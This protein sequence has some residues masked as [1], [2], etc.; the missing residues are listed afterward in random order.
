MNL[1]RSLGSV[2]G[3][4]LASRILGARSRHAVRAVRRRQFRVRRFRRRLADAEHVPR[5][6]RGRRLLGG[7]H[8]DVQQKVADKEGPG[9]R[10]AST[11]PTMRCR[12][13]CPSCVLMTVL[14][15]LFAWPATYLISRD[16][17]GAVAR[18]VRLRGNAQP[19]HLPVPDADLL[20]SLLGGILNSLT[21][22]GSLPRRRSCSTSRRSS[23]F[24]FFH[25]TSR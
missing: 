16:S 3:L 14:L 18:A 17:H 7:F 12:C 20:A 6:V 19:H 11:S 10:R 13:C 22:S 15:E 9:P 4:T 23:P 5:L 21:N 8:P 1:A 24:S 2:G 25:T